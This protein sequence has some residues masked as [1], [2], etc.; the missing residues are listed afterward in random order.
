M[1]QYDVVVLGAGSAGEL[2]ASVGK[3]HNE[4]SSDGLISASMDLSDISRTHTDSEDV[5]LLI[6]SLDVL[7]DV[8]HAFPTYGQALEQPLRLLSAMM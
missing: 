2:V 5:G 4:G 6:L 8:V 7:C 3:N 1:K